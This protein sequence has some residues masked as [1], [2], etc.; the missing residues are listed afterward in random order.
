M[1]EITIKNDYNLNVDCLNQIILKTSYITVCINKSNICDIHTDVL[2]VDDFLETNFK[3]NNY[4]T[5]KIFLTNDKMYRLS[6]LND[7]KI[8]KLINDYNNIVDRFISKFESFIM[9]GKNKNIEFGTWDIDIPILK[10]DNINIINIHLKEYSI[11][12]LNE[13]KEWLFVKLSLL[14]KVNGGKTR[15]DNIFKHDKI[16]N[17]YH[18]IRLYNILINIQSSYVEKILKNNN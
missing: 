13:M 16:N 1:N 17:T 15:Y 18:C 3:V 11:K 5:I 8:K 10:N 14:Y 9:K 7:F 2:E 6:I 4:Y 12:L